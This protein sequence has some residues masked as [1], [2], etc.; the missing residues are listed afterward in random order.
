MMTNTTTRRG[1]LLTV[2]AAM[3]LATSAWAIPEGPADGTPAWTQ[4]EQA[5]YSK[6]DEAPTEQ[7]QNPN[8]QTRWQMQ[9]DANH[10]DFLNRALA[11]P[12]WLG[13][14]SGNSEV[15]PLAATW[16]TVATGDPTRYA[17]APGPNGQDFYT[18]EADVAPVV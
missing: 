10:Q 8:F 5:N 1:A 13:P 9:S 12:S 17:A 14:P 18:N 2:L 4:R 6:T 15:T 7:S 3:T 11:D 16:G